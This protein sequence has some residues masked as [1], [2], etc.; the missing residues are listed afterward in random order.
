MIHIASQRRGRNR[1]R[2]Q[3]VPTEDAFRFDPDTDPDPDGCLGFDDNE[4]PNG[5]PETGKGKP[6]GREPFLAFGFHP[7]YHYLLRPNGAKE[8]ISLQS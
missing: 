7:N 1:D 5:K 3:G 2:D 6:S 4:T 8:F